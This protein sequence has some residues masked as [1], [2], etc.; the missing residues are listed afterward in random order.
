M[1]E[2]NDG[3][4]IRKAFFGGS[5]GTAENNDGPLVDMVKDFFFGCDSAKDGLDDDA[6]A[7]AIAM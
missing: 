6:L 5:D 7:A 3:I 4:G 2:Q 1:K